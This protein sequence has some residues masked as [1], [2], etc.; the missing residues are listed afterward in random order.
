MKKK[1]RI[2]LLL[3]TMILI[4]CV[5]VSA[6]AM[7]SAN[8]KAHKAFTSQLKR[9][10]KR[11][12]TSWNPKLKYVY[13]DVDGDK[14]DEL[15]TVPGFGALYQ[16]IYDYRNGKVTCVASVGQ[17]SFTKYYPKHKVIY[18]NKSG[19][20]GVLCDYYLKFGSGKYKIVAYAKY[21]YGRRSYTQKPERTTYYVNNKVVNKKRYTDYTKKLVQSEKS[22][23]FQSLKWKKY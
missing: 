9:D 14:V 7:S 8:K 17:G 10:K 15:I 20:M 5:P 11:Y 19:H 16:T 6:N 2:L 1:S 13:A 3:F 12:C 21:D 23:S 4:F 18:I 22:K